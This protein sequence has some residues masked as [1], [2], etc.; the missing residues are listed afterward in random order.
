MLVRTTG[1]GTGGMQRL[2]E[3]GVMVHLVDQELDEG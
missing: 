3:G 1:A 2:V